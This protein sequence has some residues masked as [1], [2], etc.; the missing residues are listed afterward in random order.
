MTGNSR[1]LR[2]SCVLAA[3]VVFGITTQVAALAP[4]D[5]GLVA[6]LAARA[7][8]EG[9]VAEGDHAGAIDTLLQSLRDA[10]PARPELADPAYGNGQLVSYV[11]LHLMPE[12][13]AY[14]YLEKGFKPELYETD[15]MLKVLCT[16]AIGLYGAQKDTQTAEAAYLT[17]T[18]NHIVRAIS[19]FFLS[20]PYFFENEKAFTGQYVEML[21]QDYPT[22]ELTQ[23]S[24]NFPLYAARETG[25]IIELAE[26]IGATEAKS[27]SYAPWSANLHARIQD[28]AR[29]FSGKGATTRAEA[30]A[31]LLR[32]MEEARDWR[33]RHFSLLLMKGEFDGPLGAEMRDGARHLAGRK[34]NTPDVL[35]ARVLLA[36]TLSADC[37][38]E[39]EDV[40]ILEETL[41]VA[42][43][44]LE[45][46][47][48]VTTPE[49]VMWETWA[50]GLQGCARNLAAAGHH[51]EALALYTA[52]E[53][54]I[55]GSKIAA[56]CEEARAELL[57][58]DSSLL[59]GVVE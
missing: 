58:N 46:G 3:C 53:A 40:E 7:T 10:D 6:L 30:V 56:A 50:Y 52:L 2:V 42:E 27:L 43:T 45:T 47:V 39:P 20:N 54:R 48:G 36:E 19:I 13:A 41:S 49:R 14:T 59:Q 1:F 22:L 9:Q 26:E 16:L 34:E 25:D 11:L 5:P 29:N 32:G 15:K 17:D 8:A 18:E 38:R 44:L 51:E 28:S 37:A 12:P 24:L 57:R 23:V 21:S 35:Q 4:D 33:E 55:P 31:P